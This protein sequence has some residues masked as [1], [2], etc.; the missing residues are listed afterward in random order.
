MGEVRGGRSVVRDPWPVF[1]EQSDWRA[2]SMVFEVSW[3]GHSR[4][5][6]G[7]RDPPPTIF[8]RMSF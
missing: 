2:R 8:A 1:R 6:V 7:L 3:F 4:V 5:G